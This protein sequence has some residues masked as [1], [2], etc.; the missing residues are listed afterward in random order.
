MHWL[1][2]HLLRPVR[3][4]VWRGAAV[5]R[6]LAALVAPEDLEEAVLVLGPLGRPRVKVE[7]LDDVLG[8]SLVLV[9]ELG[10]VVDERLLQVA[11][12]LLPDGL[13]HGEV[14]LEVL[15]VP[16]RYRSVRL[17]LG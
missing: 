15:H 12:H 5:P 7:G 9:G 16:L 1:D 6:V 13:L 17:K 4:R 8:V 3:G 2:H 11:H 14:P 10:G